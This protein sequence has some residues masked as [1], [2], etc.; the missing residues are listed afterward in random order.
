M[1]LI[2]EPCN[3][4]GQEAQLATSKQI[5]QSHMLPSLDDR[6]HAKK[7]KISIDL[8]IKKSSN[9]IGQDVQLVASNQM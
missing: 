6:F 1:M 3:L 5:W 7:S 9:L 2:E 8:M 4:I